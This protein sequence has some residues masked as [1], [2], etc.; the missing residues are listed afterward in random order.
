MRARSGLMGSFGYGVL[1]GVSC[2]EVGVLDPSILKTERPPRYLTL[3][4]LVTGELSM[5]HAPCGAALS[6]GS[7]FVLWDYAEMSRLRR[8][9]KRQVRLSSSAVQATHSTGTS[10]LDWTPRCLNCPKNPDEGQALRFVPAS[11]GAGHE[12]PG[13]NS[14]PGIASRGRAH[15]SQMSHPV[16]PLPN[17]IR[18][19]ERAP[20]LRGV[21]NRQAGWRIFRG[22][23]CR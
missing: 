19:R 18:E 20:I 9:T 15:C 12:R 21:R 11:P 14:I 5:R 22:C 3:T 16:H 7:G 4:Q 13:S 17:S 2:L 10:H 1:I 23:A 8:A 6:R